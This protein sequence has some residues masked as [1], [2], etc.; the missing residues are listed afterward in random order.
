MIGYF[1]KNMSKIPGDNGSSINIPIAI[2][3]NILANINI[4]KASVLVV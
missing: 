3:I 4:T 2:K 1:R